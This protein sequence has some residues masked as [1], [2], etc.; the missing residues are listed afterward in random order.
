[1]P[2][3][4]G[5][6]MVLAI[7]NIQESEADDELS[8]FTPGPKNKFR[9]TLEPIMM[10]LLLGVTINSEYSWLGWSGCLAI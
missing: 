10:L 2:Q 3:D 1:M 9:L 7:G 4:E 5:G 8:V 6:K